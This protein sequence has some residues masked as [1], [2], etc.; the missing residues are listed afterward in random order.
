MIVSATYG[1]TAASQQILQLGNQVIYK[2]V[3]DLDSF[4]LLVGR[5]VAFDCSFGISS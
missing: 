1:S 2:Q 5:P 4:P 3:G